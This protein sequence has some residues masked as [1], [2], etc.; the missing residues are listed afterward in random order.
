MES[1]A[2]VTW[3]YPKRSGDGLEFGYPLLRLLA[4]VE[5]GT[6]AVLAARFGPESEGELPY[7]RYLLSCLNTSMLL[8][9]DAAFDAVE[10][11]RDVTATGA[12]FLVRS[13]ARRRPTIQHRLP[14][15]SY[16]ARLAAPYRAGNGYRT[17]PVRVIEAW[18][19]VTLA[20]GTT[21][22]EPWRLVTNLLD[23][24][25]YPAGELVELYHRR[26]QV[27]TT[28]FSIKASPSRAAEDR[29]SA[30]SWRTASGCRRWRS[31]S[32]AAEDRNTDPP[33]TRSPR[34]PRGGRPPPGPRIETG[35]PG[36]RRPA[37]AEWSLF[38]A[39]KDRNM[40]DV[41]STVAVTKRR[42]PFGAT[43]DRSGYLLPPEHLKLHRGG[44]PSG[45]P[46]I[47]IPGQGWCTPGVL[48]WRSPLGRP[49]IATSIPT[50]C[51]A[52]RRPWRSPSRAHR[53]NGVRFTARKWGF[54][55][56]C[57]RSGSPTPGRSRPARAASSAYPAAREGSL[58]GLRT[59]LPGTR[60]RC[61]FAGPARATVATATRRA[62]CRRRQGERIGV[63][64]PGLG[65]G[66]GR[67]R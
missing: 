64:L 25:R 21:R 2:Q 7:A 29:N 36:D 51:A 31:P 20:D 48:R 35:A 10:F 58:R 9:G 66:L 17:L 8:L 45:Q 11:L 38:G 41:Y 61:S 26:W 46:R 6:R 42:L 30:H 14:D 40:A 55:A 56:D 22:R 24:E 49:R 32:W 23:H 18:I 53:R 67:G 4:V 65:R 52:P 44:R 1:S 19:T 34:P 39:T 37:P 5:C 60:G 57:P 50:R 54:C 16:L 63:G 13:S 3:Y 33:A 28:Y 62:A 59:A 47:A 15:G 27:E 12:H 43:E